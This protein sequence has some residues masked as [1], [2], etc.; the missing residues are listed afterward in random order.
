MELQPFRDADAVM[1]A[2]WL[3]DERV[4][5]DTAP[6]WTHPIT[7][8]GIR[9]AY[10]QEMSDRDLLCAVSEGRVVG[11]LGI[12][13]GFGTGHLF[14]VI[15]DPGLKGLGV[16]TAMVRAAVKHAFG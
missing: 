13:Y 7:A 16:G 4:L 6:D 15:V 12:R 9:K 14:H 5:A 1:L 10:G 8:D 3:A 2:A 11:H